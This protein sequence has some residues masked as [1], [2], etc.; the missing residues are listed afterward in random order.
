MKRLLF[1]A[2]ACLSSP[3]VPLGDSLGRFPREVAPPPGVARASGAVMI[4][5][6]NALQL[7]SGTWLRAGLVGVWLGL[8]FP[9]KRDSQNRPRTRAPAPTRAHTRAAA[10]ARAVLD[11]NRLTRVMYLSKL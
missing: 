1:D 3:P 2:L 4:G 5:D 8:P 6:A 11:R 7:A 10:H 9:A